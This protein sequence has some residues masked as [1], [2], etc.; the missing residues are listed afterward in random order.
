MEQVDGPILVVGDLNFTDQEHEYKLLT[1]T[2]EDAH[3]E[4]GWGMGFSFS[5]LPSSGIAM[6][7]IDYVLYSKEFVVLNTQTGEF[8][9]SDHRPVIAILGWRQ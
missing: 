4:S 9:G 2:L 7:R 3:R 5:R 8:N 1:G 6:W